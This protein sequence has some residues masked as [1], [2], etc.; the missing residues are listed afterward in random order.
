MSSAYGLEKRVGQVGDDR[1]FGRNLR[2]GLLCAEQS[3]FFLAGAFLAAGLAV[4]FAGAFLA[5][6]LAAVFDAVVF[7]GAFLAAGLAA[8]LAAG[9]DAVFFAGV[10]FAAGFDAGIYTLPIG[11]DGRIRANGVLWIFPAMLI[12]TFFTDINR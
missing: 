8:D 7:A 4:V 2:P 6:G 11:Y 1:G 5:A 12:S 10:F 9:F 3:Y